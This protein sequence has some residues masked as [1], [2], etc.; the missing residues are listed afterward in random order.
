MTR[1]LTPESLREITT[2]LT[3]AHEAFHRHYPGASLERQP[4]HVVYGGAHIF[5]SG[6]SR[7]FGELALGSLDEY[8]PDIARFA[9]AVGLEGADPVVLNADVG[10]NTKYADA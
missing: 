1:T 6:V 9:K 3:Q 5:H 4:V 10:G 7:R 8:A 2:R